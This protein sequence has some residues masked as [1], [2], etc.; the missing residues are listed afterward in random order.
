[1]LFEWNVKKT[2]PLTVKIF[3]VVVVVDLGVRFAFYDILV[4]SKWIWH[5]V[6]MLFVTWIMVTYS[7]NLR[8]SKK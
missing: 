8:E 2:I 3:G 6:Q 1:M 5:F 7:V 4:D